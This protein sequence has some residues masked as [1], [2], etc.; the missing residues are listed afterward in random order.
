MSA[1]DSAWTIQEQTLESLAAEY[2]QRANPEDKD[3][4]P[5]PEPD[6]DPLIH[7]PDTEEGQ[8]HRMIE[9]LANLRGIVQRVQEEAAFSAHL[10]TFFRAAT[11]S[12]LAGEQ[13]PTSANVSKI[14]KD[15]DA[16]TLSDEKDKTQI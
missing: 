15:F 13:Q 7:V 10:D 8:M 4:A 16:V 3:Y 6:Y 5:P 9:V 14:M 12:N 2:S 11:E 1:E